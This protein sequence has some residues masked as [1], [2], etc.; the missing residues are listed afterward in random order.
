M[1]IFNTEGFSGFNFTALAGRLCTDIGF[2]IKICDIL[3]K[4]TKNVI[5]GSPLP[6]V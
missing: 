1:P 4:T 2:D 6:R 5:Q 3:R